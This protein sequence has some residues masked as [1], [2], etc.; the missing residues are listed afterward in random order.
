[1]DSQPELFAQHYDEAGLIEKSVE[2]WGKAGRRSAARSAMAEAAAQFQKGLDQ[3]A[4]LREIPE[5]RAKELEFYS[6]LGAAVTLVKGFA[7]PETG[8]AYGR[9]L[10]LW[11]QLGSPSEF[12][13]IPLQ[14]STYHAL[15]GEFDLALQL[16]KDV[17]RLSQ[18]RDEPIGLMRAH[19]KLGNHLMFTGEFAASRL[20]LEA[21]LGLHDPIS[22]RA[23]VQW[24]ARVGPLQQ[25]QVSQR[26]NLGIVLFCLGYPDQSLADVSAIIAEA[27]RLAHPPSLVL[28]QVFGAILLSLVGDNAA[29][30]ERADELLAGAIEQGFSLY[31]AQGMIFS[32]WV[33][34]KLGNVSEGID[35]LRSGS[36]A[37]RAAGSEVWMPHYRALLAT[38][39][40]IA[41]QVEEALTLLDH[42]LRIMEKTGERWFAAELNRLKGQLL[43]RTRRYEAA[44]ELY[45]KAL[46][47][48][49]EQEA[50]LW[51]LRAATSL[52]QLWRDQG[53]RAEARDL[54]AP[55]YDWF[56]EGFDTPDLKEARELL[57]EVA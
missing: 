19:Q 7:A 29:L 20:H 55:V 42:A 11:E 32:G 12:V 30:H 23:L 25:I 16:V 57:A 45:R 34:V 51:E 15:R 48:A 46:G 9:A 22:H 33:N 37:Y 26:G 6:G 13:N 1:M 38:A 49:R 8:H 3:L 2:F 5:R 27:R 17:L 39:L 44:E 4:L 47:I 35:L 54:L 53:R 36:D 24:A 50:K 14:Q 18:Q 52:A 31:R 43:L 40:E 41:G 10:E 21:G 28:S 56:T